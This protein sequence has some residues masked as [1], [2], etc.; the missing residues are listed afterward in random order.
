MTAEIANPLDPR[1]P[2]PHSGDKA[3]SGPKPRQSQAEIHSPQPHPRPTRGLKHPLGN[4]NDIAG[5]K[6]IRPIRAL[7]NFAVIHDAHLSLKVVTAPE[8][9]IN[10][11]L[12]GLAWSAKPPA[13]AIADARSR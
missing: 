3:Q 6:R 5:L 2:P 7:R 4:G 9:R 10:W 11:M 1:Q 13:V 12:F 8:A